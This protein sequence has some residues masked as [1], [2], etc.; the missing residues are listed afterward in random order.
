MSLEWFLS[1]LLGTLGSVLFGQFESGTS[2]KGRLGK[3]LFYLAV[4][5]LLARKGRPWT[6]IWVLFIPVSA[7]ALHIWW[8]R[9][10]GINPLTAEPKEKYYQLRG[11][12]LDMST[13]NV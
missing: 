1:A 10:H 3:W 13:S 6:L 2:A 5:G 11:W 9:K 8:C 4:T 12:S 7:S